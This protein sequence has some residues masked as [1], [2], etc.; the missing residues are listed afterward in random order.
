MKLV[1]LGLII[2]IQTSIISMEMENPFIKL[3]VKEM[4]ENPFSLL[5]DRWGL[6]TAGDIRSFNTM[7]IS[8]G[9]LG[10]LWNLP[11]ATVYIRPQ[12][13]TLEFVERSGLF[14]ISFFGESFREVLNYCG[15]RSGREVDKMAETG[16][17]PVV[18]EQGGIVFSQAKSYLECR[19]IYSGEILADRFIDPSIRAKNYPAKDYHRFFIGEVLNYA[20]K[21]E[22]VTS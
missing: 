18:T 3:P 19:K 22:N 2:D 1:R 21:Q 4:A 15:S 5:D 8:W 16:L 10:I 20:E 9:G 11:V 12:R 14:T 6:I 7:T 17:I 13:Y